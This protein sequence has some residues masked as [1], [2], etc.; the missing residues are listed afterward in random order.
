MHPIRNRSR[1]IFMLILL[2][3]ACIALFTFIV[4]SLWNAILPSVLHVGTVTF[5]QALGI[6]VLSKILFGGFHGRGGWGHKRNRM[7]RERMHEKWHNMTPEERESFRN[8]WRERCSKFG[9]PFSRQ[10]FQQGEPGT[11]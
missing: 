7:M 1:K 3:P 4:M 8:Q 5:W 10:P 11:E 2:I 6:L 9:R